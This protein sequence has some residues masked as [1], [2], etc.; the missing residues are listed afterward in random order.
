MKFHF[1]LIAFLF[2]TNC[3]AQQNDNRGY[4]VKVGQQAPDFSFTLLDG[5]KVTNKSLLGKTVVLQFTAS[6]CGVCIKEMPHLE[7]E[8]WQKFKK[9][10]F[11]LI[12]IDLKE[13]LETTKEFI[14]KTEVSYPFT[15]DSNG[16][17]FNSF[18]VKGAGVTRNIVIDK[19]GKIVFLTRLYNREEFEKMISVIKSELKK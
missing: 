18:T 17:I 14:N 11:I 9:D 1:L 16:D 19:T 5:T 4:K 15:L 10:D 12:G 3:Q 8:V 7:K 2:L 6:W 13:S